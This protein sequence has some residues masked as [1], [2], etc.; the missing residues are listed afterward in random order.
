M[1]LLSTTHVVE[2]RTAVGSAHVVADTDRIDQVFENLIGN[3]VKYSPGGGTVSLNVGIEGSEAL[4][5]VNRLMHASNERDR[6][7]NVDHCNV[8][9]CT[10]RRGID[11][12]E[13]RVSENTE[14]LPVRDKC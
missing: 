5:S 13:Y 8:K 9:S 10:G 14:P 11:S 4:V 12:F 6:F 2:M 1:R 7:L 3:A